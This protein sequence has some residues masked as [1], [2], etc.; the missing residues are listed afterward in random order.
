MTE[1]LFT[2]FTAGSIQL[3]NRIVMAPLTRNRARHE[4]DVPAEL[5]IEYY[6]QRATAGLI[7]TEGSQISPEGKGYAW[8]PGIYSA[9]QIDAWRKIT[10]AVHEAG[11]K[12]V[13]QLWHVGRVSH[14]VLQPGGQAP[15]APSAI[16]AETRVYDG[17]RFVAAS[18]PRALEVAEIARIV[19]DYAKATRN[20]REAGFDGVEIHAANGYLVNQFL[21]DGSNTRSDAYG[22]SIGNRARFLF[23]VVDAVVGAWD[24]EHVGIRLSP[25]SNAN[26]V[27]DSDPMALFS[28]V[29]QG[30]DQRGLAF[31]HVIEGQT[32]GTR[33]LPEGCDL[34]ALRAMFRGAYIGNNGYDRESAIA[35]VESGRADL[36][37]FGRAF[38]ANP[39]LVARLRKDAPLNAPDKTTFYGGGAEGYTDYPALA[40]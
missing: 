11:G 15:V 5:S 14:D 35:A 10:D 36:V 19:S 23:D 9:Q 13:L 20:A 7:V 26:G 34:G 24:A 2:P 38:I 4:D 6:R 18:M 22:G 3:A 31:L 21:C 30:L 25:F 27:A 16:A 37:A 1:K 8:T 32:G 17:E 33:D 28:H 39:D 40:D 12:I 29:V